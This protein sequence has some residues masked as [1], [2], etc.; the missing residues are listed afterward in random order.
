MFSFVLKK[1]FIGFPKGGKKSKMVRKTKIIAAVL[2][3]AAIMIGGSAAYA[4]DGANNTATQSSTK[5]KTYTVKKGDNLS[6]IAKEYQISVRELMKANNLTESLIRPGDV[7]Q[8]PE[9]LSY[10]ERLSRGDVSREEFLLMAKLIH[11]EA[12]GES[13]EGQVA[14]GAVVMNRL[15]SPHFPKTI[16][17]V[18]LQKNNN[19]YQF[20]PVSDGSINLEPDE[21]AFRAAEQALAGNDPTGGALFFYNPDI[22]TDPWI[23]TLPVVKRIGN[24]V[25]ATC[26]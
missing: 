10:A 15:N 20:S 5:A 1:I 8:I 23:R 7:L 12:R 4:N 22:S 17:E 19:V 24:H 6:L 25:F 3:S 21:K 14:V 18:I 26:T 9:T 2:F 13:F 11:A 16:A